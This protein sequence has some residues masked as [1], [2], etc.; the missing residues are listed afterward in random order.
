MTKIGASFILSGEVLGERPM[1]QNRNSLSLI[2]TESGFKGR[3][4]RPLSALLLPETI[5]EKEGLVNKNKLLNISGRSRKRQMELAAKMNLK[6][7]P[8]PAGGC[9]L[10]EPGFSKRLRDLF[11]QE[12]YFLEEIE[13]L[14]LG[15]HFRLGRDIKLVV[16]RNK[17]ENEQLKD[18]FQEGDFLFK[19]K[20]LKGPISLIKK[21]FKLNNDFID[22]SCQIT[23]RYCDRNE[24]EDEEVYI[25]Y[26][27]AS[28]ELAK[29][30]KVKPLREEELEI[31]RV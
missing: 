10:T 12:K 3:I 23:A 27:S 11:N 14:K 2:E 25:N 7:Y 26:Y 29:T 22:K 4:L 31:L 13:L 20:N 8:S 5:P 17:E 1:S 19:A 18:F 24:E 9:K 15:R 6:D 30:R 21:G 16:G 28:K